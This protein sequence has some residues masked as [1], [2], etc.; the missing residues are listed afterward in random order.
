VVCDP[1]GVEVVVRVQRGGRADRHVLVGNVEATQADASE[2][3]LEQC[4][5]GRRPETVRPIV[6]L[7]P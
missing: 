6:L 2:P 3:C 4:L 1:V 5:G 7:E